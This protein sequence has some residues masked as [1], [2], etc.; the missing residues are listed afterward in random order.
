MVVLTFTYQPIAF[1]TMIILFCVWLTPNV[2]RWCFVEYWD[3][4]LILIISPRLTILS[5]RHLFLFSCRCCW[6]AINWRDPNWTLA[7]PVWNFHI[8]SK[9]APYGMY[10]IQVYPW[11]WAWTGRNPPI[12]S[13]LMFFWCDWDSPLTIVLSTPSRCF[14]IWTC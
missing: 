10:S 7:F 1:M 2:A 12:C 13:L 5:M 3:W 11:P 6:L 9:I 14:N 4:C 8:N